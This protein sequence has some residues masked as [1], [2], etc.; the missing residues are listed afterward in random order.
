MVDP[1]AASEGL[2]AQET[3]SL[4]FTIVL[5]EFLLGGHPGAVVFPPLP[6][7]FVRG[8]PLRFPASG[9]RAESL[10]IVQRLEFLLAARIDTGAEGSW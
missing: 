5:P 1:L 9:G 2:A 4:F 3:A 10:F 8:L 6:A 7:V